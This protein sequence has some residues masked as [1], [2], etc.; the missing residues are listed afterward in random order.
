MLHLCATITADL[1]SVISALCPTLHQSTR[2]YPSVCIPHRCRARSMRPP[3][4]G[5][6]TTRSTHLSRPRQVTECWHVVIRLVANL[7]VSRGS[8]DPINN[9]MPHHSYSHNTRSQ[10]RDVV[11]RFMCK[12]VNLLV[13]ISLHKLSEAGLSVTK[14]TSKIA[15]YSLIRRPKA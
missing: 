10:D 9:D 3:L 2:L 12:W 1:R 4:L 15:P 5:C 7:F 13:K 8:A 11:F 6:L 14:S